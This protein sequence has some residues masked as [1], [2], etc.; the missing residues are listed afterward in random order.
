MLARLLNSPRKLVKR[1][2]QLL[3]FV[4]HRAEHAE[5]LH[6]IRMA[7]QAGVASDDKLIDLKYLGVYLSEFMNTEARRQIL[8]HHYGFLTRKITDPRLG[9]RWTTGATLWER[10]DEA[11]GHA[12]NIV[13]EQ[14]ALS[15]MEGES[16]LRFTMGDLTLC[17]LTFSFLRGRDI[18]LPHGEVIFIGGVQGGVD[19]REQIRMAAKSNGEIV[20]NAM[21]L[22]ASKALA[23]AMGIGYIVGVSS[24][25]QAAMGYAGEKIS[26]NTMRCGRKPVQFTL[27]TAIS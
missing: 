27:I 2:R 13:V 9:A 15:P 12:F 8:M 16:Q 20:P 4:S 23:Q 19:C 25:G 3:H 21:L 14:S 18:N 11:L 24:D 10:R 22:V 7:R 26:L 6:V 5:Y 17:T 1:T